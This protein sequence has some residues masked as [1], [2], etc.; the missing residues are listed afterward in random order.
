MAIYIIIAWTADQSIIA[1]ISIN[2]NTS[3]SHCNGI[4]IGTS[5]PSISINIYVCSLYTYE[6]IIC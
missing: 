6:S 1:R 5:I 4:D 2:I 3:C